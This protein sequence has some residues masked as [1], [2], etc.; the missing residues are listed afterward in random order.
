MTSSLAADIDARCRLTG[1]FRLRS[2]RTS[3]EYFDKYLFESDPALLRRV[4]E[5]MVPLVPAGAD[6]LGG[7][8]LGGVP[9]AVMVGQLTGRPVVLVRKKAKEYGTCRLAEGCDVGGRTVV[10]IEDVVTS[11]GAVLAAVRELRALGATVTDAV[12]V[13]DRQE[14]GA[15]ALAER[16]VTLHAV[17]TRADLDAAHA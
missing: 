9:L 6:L 2:G 4:A 13:I 15:A 7:L 1:S 14:S 16:D 10:L 12:C 17:L 11:G 3:T 8:E 5:A